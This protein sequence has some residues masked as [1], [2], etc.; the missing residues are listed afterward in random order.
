MQEM[1]HVNVMRESYEI[2]K[3]DPFINDKQRIKLICQKINP[4]ANKIVL[5]IAYEGL[6]GVNL[7]KGILSN[8]NLDPKKTKIISAVES[9]DFEDYEVE[10]THTACCNA[11]NFYTMV[12]QK[13]IDWDAIKLSHYFIA[14]SHRPNVS[15]AILIKYMLDFFKDES[16]L[17]FGFSGGITK[18]VKDILYP[19]TA[20]LFLDL[21]VSNVFRTDDLHVPPS[22]LML[23]ALFN[24]VLETNDALDTEIRLTE[25]TYKPFA[26]HQIPIFIAPQGH[27]KVVRELGFDLFDDI[28]DNH[29]YSKN[30]QTY[31][32]AVISL[33]KKILKKYDTLEKL[34]NLRATLMDRL[35]YNN[36]LLASYVER[37]GRVW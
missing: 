7:L 4:L 13:N 21:D 12:K 3:L 16:L 9:R 33:L 22:D 35:K 23:K 28:L 25:K 15:R 6:A 27:I 11:F 32:L 30:A 5:D 37:D 14:L 8:L 29:N 26:W 18:E 36:S 17:S 19:H 24:I 1:C 2:T 34:Q 20:P 31:S 10:I